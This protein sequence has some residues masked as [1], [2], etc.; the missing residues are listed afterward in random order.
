MKI[1]F[2]HHWTDHHWVT[3]SFNGSASAIISSVSDSV[4]GARNFPR[5]L[6]RVQ[7]TAAANSLLLMR[8]STKPNTHWNI[9]TNLYLYIWKWQRQIQIQTL[10]VRMPRQTLFF[11]WEKNSTAEFDALVWVARTIQKVAG[12]KILANHK[13]EYAKSCL[14]KGKLRKQAAL[15]FILD[16]YV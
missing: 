7:E 15:W 14:L 16:T 3:K 6:L 12:I 11:S 2:P 4:A 10:W 8:N 13:G 9:N 1:A 5:T